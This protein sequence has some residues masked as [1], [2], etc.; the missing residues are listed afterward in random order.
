MG[1]PLLALAKYIYYHLLD[2]LQQCTKFQLHS[3]L[4]SFTKPHLK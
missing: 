2:L 1:A 3:M 4:G